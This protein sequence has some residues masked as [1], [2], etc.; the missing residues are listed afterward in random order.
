M[1]ISIIIPCYNSGETI[2]KCLESITKQKY[3][4]YEVITVVD[5][6]SSDNTLQ[7]CRAWK[8]S[9]KNKLKIVEVEH[10]GV[11]RKRNYASKI[12]KGDVLLFLD[13][14][15]ELEDENYLKLLA[16]LF[17][18]T[19]ADVITG[20]PVTPKE[21][22]L[23]EWVLSQEYEQRFY[24]VGDCYID[25]AAT[26]CMAVKKK[27]LEKVRFDESISTKQALGEDFAF[28]FNLIKKGCKIFH[29]NELKVYH[30]FYS[31][32]KKYLI[33]QMRHAEYRVMLARKHGKVT[34][35]YTNPIPRLQA[36]LWLLFPICFIWYELFIPT[37]ILLFL[38]QLPTAI[39]IFLRTKNVK[40]FLLLP[41]SVIRSLFWLIG[42]VK[43]LM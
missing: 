23:I 37:L 18:A 7:I 15:A 16:Y 3:D 42:A 41:V 32:F 13:S 35:K 36:F 10:C 12:A 19:N 24:D 43:A 27:V 25:C 31:N 8:K 17:T 38:W 1:L 33:E 6:K 34:D 20:V 40:S 14:D 29:T 4:D 28:S 22:S 11:A 26:T 5:K 39:K 2:D 9:F 21:A 30:Y